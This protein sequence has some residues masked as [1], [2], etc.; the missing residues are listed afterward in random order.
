MKNSEL[1]ALAEEGKI[2]KGDI[3]VDQDENEIIFTGR[4]FQTFFT[5][6]YDEYELVGMCIGDTWKFSHNNINEFL[7]RANERR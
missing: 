7:L 3:Y 4:S 6:K 5:N 2:N 1:W